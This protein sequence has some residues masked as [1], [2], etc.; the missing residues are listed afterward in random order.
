MHFG[1]NIRYVTIQSHN[2]NGLIERNHDPLRRTFE[3]VCMNYSGI[4]DNLA[5]SCA[6][7]AEN[8]TLGQEGIVPVT[9]VLG[10]TPCTGAKFPNQPEL[11]RAML[12]ACE[13]MQ[14]ISARKK[15]STVQ[16]YVQSYPQQTQFTPWG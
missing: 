2:L 5:L 16:S 7:S 12:T 3:K 4:S 10:I 15:G 14:T 1:I 6:V 8:D 13:E 9:F 11:I